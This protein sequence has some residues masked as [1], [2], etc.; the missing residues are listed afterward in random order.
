VS[1]V[2]SVVGWGLT[3]HVCRF[4]A[5]WWYRELLAAG[6]FVNMC[7]EASSLWLSKW[8]DDVGG[9]CDESTGSEKRRGQRVNVGRLC[10]IGKWLIGKYK[11]LNFPFR[12]A[13]IV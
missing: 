9:R 7:C 1:Y 6:W 4:V 8:V 13:S 10:Q 11:L 3:L 12:K 2:F 5:G